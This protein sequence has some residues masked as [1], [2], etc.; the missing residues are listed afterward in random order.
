[1][2]GCFGGGVLE[3]DRF[4]DYHG[5]LASQLQHDGHQV[6]SRG[7]CHQLAFLGAPCEDDQVRLRCRGSDGDVDP[8]IDALVA[9][10]IQ[11]LP[12]EELGSFC[13]MRR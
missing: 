3:I 10:G 6:L 12:E 4:V 11:V 1:M 9:I 8:S 13:H 5:A 7:L 2:L